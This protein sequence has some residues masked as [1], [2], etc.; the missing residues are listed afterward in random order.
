[1]GGGSRVEAGI[2]GVRDGRNGKKRE[3]LGDE[4]VADYY[5]FLNV[6]LCALPFRCY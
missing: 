5:F 1:M 4:D 2:E 3:N 6:S